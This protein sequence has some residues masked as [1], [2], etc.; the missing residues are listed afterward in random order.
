MRAAA[1]IVGALVVFGLAAGRLLYRRRR[2]SRV[3]DRLGFASHFLL[4]A[5]VAV[6]CGWSALRLAR[7]HDSLH[8]G[9]ATFLGL[10]MLWSIFMAGVFAWGLWH[11]PPSDL[12]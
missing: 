2:G 12:E 8:L 1:V 5:Y 6:I 11:P 4:R 3:P 7:H 10:L 9:L